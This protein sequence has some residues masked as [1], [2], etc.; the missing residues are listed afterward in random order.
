VSTR[1]SIFYSDDFHVYTDMAGPDDNDETIFVG[2]SGPWEGSSPGGVTVEQNRDK[3]AA[4]CRAY[5]ADYEQWRAWKDK[6]A[7][8]RGA[9]LLELLILIVGLGVAGLV[10]CASIGAAL[11]QRDSA[12]EKATAE[13]RR[14][15]QATTALAKLTT[16]SQ[17]LRAEVEM[18]RA[19]DDD[20]CPCTCG[21]AE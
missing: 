16:R 7:T 4:M 19:I 12:R 9:S 14:A 11:S 1:A 15:D 21:D 8:P 20:R 2:M 3:W 18:H 17:R 6:Q 5:L 10:A 13:E